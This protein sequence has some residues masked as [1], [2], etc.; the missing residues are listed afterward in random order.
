M[1]MEENNMTVFL[2]MI[3]K[4]LLKNMSY[5][6]ENGKIFHTTPLQYI[7]FAKNS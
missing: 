6:K 7:I 4:I 3:K 5:I 1:L 2:F